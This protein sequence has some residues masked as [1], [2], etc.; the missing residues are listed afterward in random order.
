MVKLCGIAA[1]QTSTAAGVFDFLSVVG[2][3]ATEN[4][5]F[6]RVDCLFAGI[7]CDDRC[8]EGGVAGWIIGVVCVIGVIVVAAV[9]VFL[10]VRRKRRGYERK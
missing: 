1:A 7:E 8:M 9:V 6:I 10:I 3:E 4:N 2:P 5:V